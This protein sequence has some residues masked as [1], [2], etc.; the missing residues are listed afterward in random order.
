[1]RPFPFYSDVLYDSHG[2]AELAVG[3]FSAAY[4]PQHHC[5]GVY[6]FI[7][8][9]LLVVK[10]LWR[11]PVLNIIFFTSV[12]RYIVIISASG[13]HDSSKSAT[14]AVKT[15][16]FSMTKILRLLRYRYMIGGLI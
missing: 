10:Q 5:K 11:H 14:F 4:F 2:R 3:S 16:Y 13:L 1:M 8:R 6:I 9:V 7:K 15:P 12:P